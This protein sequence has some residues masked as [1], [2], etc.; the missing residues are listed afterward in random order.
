MKPIGVVLAGGLGKRIG[1]DKAVVELDGRPLLRY[2]LAA[3]KSVVDE[4]AVVAKR[5]TALPPL[6]GEASVWVEPDE[7]R[8]PLC[9]I[10]HALRLA[11]GRPVLCVAADMPLLDAG[12][13]GAICDA[14]SGGA[15][16]V[17][18]RVQGRLEPL[19]AL[20]LPRALAGLASFDPNVRATDAVEALGIVELQCDQYEPFFN[21]NGP[22]DVVMASA[23]RMGGAPKRRAKG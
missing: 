17:V 20:Y 23:L 4:V 16:A 12:T 7:P 10:V 1:G 14:D 13:L 11:A 9:G 2:P 3:L 18:P 22:E 21:V 6:G 8:L 19:C 5:D 15:V